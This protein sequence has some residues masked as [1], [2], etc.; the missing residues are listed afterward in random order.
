MQNTWIYLHNFWCRLTPFGCGLLCYVLGGRRH[1]IRVGS[2]HPSHCW[3]DENWID[4]EVTQEGQY[5]DCGDQCSISCC[6]HYYP[7]NGKM[8]LFEVDFSHCFPNT[9]NRIL[10]LRNLYTR[11]R[12]KENLVLGRIAKRPFTSI[13]GIFDRIPSQRGFIDSLDNSKN[14]RWIVEFDG[15][16]GLISLLF[17]IHPHWAAPIKLHASQPLKCVRLQ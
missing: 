1:R 10:R 15:N 17:I 5:F 3:N 13:L 12:C 7:S 16:V 14:E 2:G 4:A 8:E 9:C 6:L 11:T